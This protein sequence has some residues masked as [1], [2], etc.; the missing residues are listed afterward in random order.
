MKTLSI[1]C[2]PQSFTQ[3]KSRNYYYTT[4]NNATILE[5]DFGEEFVGWSKACDF[6][7][8]LGGKSQALDLGTESVVTVPLNGNLMATGMLTIQPWATVEQDGEIVKQ[9][10]QP[11][12][13]QIFSALNSS[14]AV[15]A[16]HPD[17]ISQ[18][19]A[20]LGT[21][22]ASENIKALRLNA[23][24][25]EYTIDNTNWTVLSTGEGS[26]GPAYWG[27][28]L[29]SISN[30][31]D[32]QAALNSKANAVHNHDTSY[33]TKTN[34]DAL[35]NNK[36]NAAH[37][38]DDRYYTESEIN[39]FLAQKLD[40]SAYTANDVLDKIKTVDGV[41]SGLDADTLQGKQPSAFVL[42]SE[43]GTVNGVATLDDTGKVPATQ[44]PSYV[45]DVVEYTDLASFPATGEAGKI[46][47]ATNAGLIYRWTGSTYVEISSAGTADVALKLQTARTIALSGGVSGSAAFDGSQNITINTTVADDSHNHSALH[48]HSNKALLDTYTQ[49]DASLADAVA[50]I[51]N[52]SNRA[53]LDAIRNNGGGTQFLADDG[54]YRAI[55]KT[56][57]FS[58]PGDAF[59]KTNFAGWI[60]DKSYTIQRVKIYADTAPVGADLIID[61]NKNNTTIFTT[62]TNRPK[63][64]A[65]TNAGTDVTTIEVNTLSAGDR[66]SIDIDQ[67]GSTTPG[68]NN[69]LVTVV[70]V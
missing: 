17:E 57:S 44:L 36:A 15:F 24:Q 11:V 53:A 34:V 23:G 51:H 64:T 32:L 69:L 27:Q 6:E 14:Q 38:H 9:V 61:I 59:V 45:D 41:G 7:N 43:K 66:L 8:A 63:V 29:G 70:L 65:G 21:K 40:I 68:G 47:V 10:F 1:K 20:L 2:T 56:I 62:Q 19:L 13:I 16:E 33:Y 25:I 58:I 55:S 37:I 28:I 30:Q 22:I 18:L 12:K 39:A 50:N 3:L 52:H 26:S 60:A 42:N 49:T 31:A 5:L 54:T 4:E 48:V 46:Y 67:V 35:L